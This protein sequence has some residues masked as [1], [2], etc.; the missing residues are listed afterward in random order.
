M[1]SEK[2]EKAKQAAEAVVK[3]KEKGRAKGV[4]RD[5]LAWA[6][7][8]VA[9]AAFW[10]LVAMLVIGT[11]SAVLP[12]VAANMVVL[13]GVTGESAWYVWLELSVIPFLFV[14]G[15]MFIGEAA[16]IRKL[17]GWFSRRVI[18]RIDRIGIKRGSWQ[19]RG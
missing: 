19:D 16:L 12:L 3:E 6:A 14:A 10:T 11:A 17:M 7:K 9:W 5:A 15:L 4:V 18:K 13:S 8:G 2:A 1:A